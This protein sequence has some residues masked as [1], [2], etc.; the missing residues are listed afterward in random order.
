MK[1]TSD[2]KAAVQSKSLGSLT[3]DLGK[4]A[5]ELAYQLKPPHTEIKQYKAAEEAEHYAIGFSATLH[6]HYFSPVNTSE[7]LVFAIDFV[8]DALADSSNPPI[9]ELFYASRV[10]GLRIYGY[11]A[12]W[13]GR[14]VPIDECL[15][16]N[17]EVTSKTLDEMELDHFRAA[18][19][20]VD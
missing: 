12:R 7:G 4:I 18:L 5:E 6:L 1:K 3:K 13:R 20:Q 15:R 11:G 2:L 10:E 9:H 16:R 19:G 8:G 14:T 17:L